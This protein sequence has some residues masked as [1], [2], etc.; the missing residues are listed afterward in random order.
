MFNG[1]TAPPKLNDRVA[2][3]KSATVEHGES[4]IGAIDNTISPIMQS[5]LDERMAE[6]AKRPIKQQAR[7]L[8]S[9]R[10]SPGRTKLTLRDLDDAADE[11]LNTVKG[12]CQEVVQSLVQRGHNGRGRLIGDAEAGLLINYLM[13]TQFGAG[14]FEPLF[15]ESDVEDIIISSVA[16]GRRSTK[17]KVSTYRQSGKREEKIDVE[18]ADVIEMVNRA[19]RR[20]GRQ[21]SPV[22]PILNAQMPNGARIN[23]VLN[24]VCDPY[25]RVTIR[26][27]RLIA[28]TFTDLV[29]LGTLSIPAAAWLYL[30][31]RSKLSICVAGGTSSGKTNLLNALSTVIDPEENIICIEGRE[32]MR[33]VSSK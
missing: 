30:S 21:L 4:P 11:T 12:Y 19:A 23:A 28:R 6:L 16:S 7:A 3:N 13:A 5:I 26:V 17:I 25:L 27:H 9:E 33:Q 20:Q 14:E 10:L 29:E 32:L 2:L 24:P 22:T 1:K 31:I 18:P 8:L 15:H